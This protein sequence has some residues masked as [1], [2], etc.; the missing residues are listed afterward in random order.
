MATSDSAEAE[1]VGWLQRAMEED[2]KRHG[3]RGLG[4]WK[5]L[6][7]RFAKFLR[8]QNTGAPG[9]ERGYVVA[10]KRCDAEVMVF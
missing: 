1:D 6:C 9:W 7:G 4:G 5:C 8:W 2:V 3:N 10:C